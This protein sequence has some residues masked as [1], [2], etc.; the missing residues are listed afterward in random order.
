MTDTPKLTTRE[1]QMLRGII[2]ATGKR[3]FPPTMDEMAARLKLSKTR[4]RQLYVVLERK[5]YIER[6]ARMARGLRV[7]LDPTGNRLVA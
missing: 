6:R 3:G 7:V 5:G 4:V 2:T 1:R